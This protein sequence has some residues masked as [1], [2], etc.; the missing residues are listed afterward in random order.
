MP[1]KYYR[2]KTTPTKKTKED[3]KQNKVI[4]KLSKALSNVE[5]KIMFDA[6]SATATPGQNTNA[7]V[8]KAITVTEQGD[9]GEGN[10]FGPIY[11]IRTG[12]TLAL[13]EIDYRFS[14]AYDE[15]TPN[16]FRVIMVQYFGEAVFPFPAS[17]IIQSYSVTDQA[18]LNHLSVYVADV[19][20]KSLPTSSKASWRVIAD[21]RVY[22]PGS[23]LAGVAY[24]Y[25]NQGRSFRIHKKF[26]TPIKL[27]YSG[28]TLTYGHV[29]ML[30]FPGS[31]T[32]AALNPYYNYYGRLIYSDA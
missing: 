32:N 3:R 2:K 17:D 1:R 14:V 9:L 7:M 19:R 12:N 20:Q 29:Y 23:T 26:K 24:G 15:V 25:N 30:I 10:L 22:F 8:L 28:N 18:M 27:G 13:H 31:R 21:R 4:A 11:G 16:F 5:R 6:N